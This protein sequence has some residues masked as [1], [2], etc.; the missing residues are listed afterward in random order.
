MKKNKMMRIASVLLVVTLL[1]TCIISGTF[2]KYVTKGSGSDNARVAKFGVKIESTGELFDTEYET[3]DTTYSGSLSV[4]SSNDD[5]LVAPGTT[6]NFAGFTVS[7]TPEVAV[8]MAF[9]EAT[10]TLTGWTDAANNYYC[11]L[12]IKVGNTTL[13]GADYTSI[14][15]FKAAVEAEIKNF[16]KDYDPLT[17]LSATDVP[18]IS[19]SWPFSTGDANDVKDTYLGD[20]AAAGNASTIELA[21]T[22]TVTQID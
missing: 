1:S 20:Q 7:G 9:S 22:L 6:K 18:A 13:D 8:R 4:K 21:V 15:T 17:T 10:L 12:V 19:W 5:K 14:A 3:H 11:P 16:T 2:A